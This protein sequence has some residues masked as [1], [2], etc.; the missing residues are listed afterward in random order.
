[1]RDNGIISLVTFVVFC[2]HL[3]AAA[4]VARRG[5]NNRTPLQTARTNDDGGFATARW[6][7]R[8]RTARR[9]YACSGKMAS[10]LKRE[11]ANAIIRISPL[12]LIRL[13][14]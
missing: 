12:I 2:F 14:L 6:R 1:M 11:H 8:P 9:A 10:H 13:I 4:A 5:A 3:A 7:T